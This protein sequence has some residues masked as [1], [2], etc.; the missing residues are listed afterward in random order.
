[1]GKNPRL[2]QQRKAFSTPPD[3][4]AQHLE[5][6]TVLE[7]LIWASTTHSPYTEATIRFPAAYSHGTLFGAAR[8]DS[9][10][11][12]DSCSIPEQP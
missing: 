4:D 2:Q 1:M 12:C 10:S 8:A 11:A 3:I 6:V 7:R 9:T 5:Q